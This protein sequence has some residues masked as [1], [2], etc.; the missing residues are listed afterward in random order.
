MQGAKPMRARSVLICAFC[1]SLM[2]MAGS[3]TAAPVR[4]GT[5]LM[6]DPPAGYEAKEVPSPGWAAVFEITKPTDRPIVFGLRGEKTGCKVNFR[7]VR[8]NW[9]RDQDELNKQ[10]SDPARADR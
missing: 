1:L 4:H 6:V 8:E 7:Y 2:L 5:G 10:A 9:M 3:S